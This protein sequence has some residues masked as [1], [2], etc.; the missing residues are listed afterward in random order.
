MPH[1]WA[2][3]QPVAAAH[4]TKSPTEASDWSR[5]CP[6]GQLPSFIFWLTVASATLA[7]GGLRL[8]PRSPPLTSF[9]LPLPPSLSTHTR[10]PRKHMRP[11]G[12][13]CYRQPYL[14]LTKRVLPSGSLNLEESQ[15]RSEASSEHRA[16]R[17]TQTPHFCPFPPC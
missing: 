1:P 15:S 2:P 11:S 10:G 6:G 13:Q 17:I 16:E 8:P 14:S 5:G 12:L 9:S 7:R 3:H 4:P